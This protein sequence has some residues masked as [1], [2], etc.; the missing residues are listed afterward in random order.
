CDGKK[1]SLK[2]GVPLI[3]I[4]SG[5]N[6]ELSTYLSSILYSYQ[7]RSQ[8]FQII[9]KRLESN[10]NIALSNSTKAVGT[11]YLY[12]K[13]IFPNFAASSRI[14]ITVSE[15]S[16]TNLQLYPPR[17][18]PLQVIDEKGNAVAVNQENIKLYLRDQNGN[19]ISVPNTGKS[20]STIS[21][22]ANGNLDFIFELEDLEKSGI[23]NGEV[24]VYGP[25]SAKVSQEVS[26]A[27]KDPWYLALFAIFL[28]VLV[29]FFLQ[30]WTSVGRSRA[31]LM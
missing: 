22:P 18:G 26:I 11:K 10:K 29:S 25:S 12:F 20:L 21:L 16:G 6:L 17:L 23:Y 30:S 15:T 31:I 1:Y 24:S 27:V 19:L 9:I 5:D 3:I 28:G 13:N 2:P 7:G 4:I 14:Y 8:S